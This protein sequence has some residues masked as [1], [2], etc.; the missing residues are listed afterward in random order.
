MSCT[1]EHVR[2]QT[3]DGVNEAAFLKASETVMDWLRR[4]PG[5]QY[6]TLVKGEGA[7]WLDLC[8]WESPETAKKAG[9]AF[10]GAAEAQAFMSMIDD[11]TVE[12]R[13]LPQLQAAAGP[14]LAVPEP[15]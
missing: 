9:D 12:M 1:L 5:F 11:S 10:W 6:R 8:Y 13:H 7:E 3:R 14:A 4:Q 2:F 15:A